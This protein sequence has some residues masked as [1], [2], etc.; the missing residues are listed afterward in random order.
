MAWDFSGVGPMTCHISGG[1][2]WIGGRG[3]TFPGADLAIADGDVLPR[4]DLICVRAA[5]ETGVE[6]LVV[7]GEPASEPEG[8]ATPDG[9][10]PLWGVRVPA[11]VTA[12]SGGI[13][14]DPT[15]E[16]AAIDRRT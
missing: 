3:R 13:E 7:V 11:G 6:L 16:Y 8:P 14:A 5:G 12:A 9:A 4:I 15:W 10:V 1:A 2:G